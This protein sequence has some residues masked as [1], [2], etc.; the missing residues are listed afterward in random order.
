MLGV[1]GVCHFDRRLG[2]RGI[3]TTYTVFFQSIPSLPKSSR[4][5]LIE[6]FS[7]LTFQEDIRASKWKIFTERFMFS[8][9]TTGQIPSNPQVRSQGADPELV[10]NWLTAARTGQGIWNGRVHQMI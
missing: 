7:F 4:Y 3:H 1:G 9:G 6:V 2:V 8:G 10:V 5:D